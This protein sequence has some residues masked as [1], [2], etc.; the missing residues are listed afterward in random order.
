MN[1]PCLR[2]AWALLAY[3]CLSGSII[4]VVNVFMWASLICML[5]TRAHTNN[6][7]NERYLVMEQDHL[8]NLK[9]VCKHRYVQISTDF[10]MTMV[11]SMVF[12]PPSELPIRR[13]MFVHGIG[14]SALSFAQTAAII[15][16]NG[17]HEVH[18]LDLP[19]FGRLA[20]H[21]R[22]ALEE[23][24]CDDV[25]HFYGQVIKG[26]MRTCG[27]MATEDT[28]VAHSF[29]GFLAARCAIDDPGS[30]GKLVL[31]SPAGLYPTLGCFG[32]HW[33]LL[34]KLGLPQ[35]LLKRL[36]VSPLLRLK[37]WSPAQR[38]HLTL[39]S[40]SRG[41]GDV[42]VAKFVHQTFTTSRWTHPMIEG[43]L[44]SKGVKLAFVHGA[45]DSLTP[46]HQLTSIMSRGDDVGL[47]VKVM[48]DAG[49][50]PYAD[51][52][53]TFANNIIE[54]AEECREPTSRQKTGRLG[55]PSDSSFDV[56]ETRRLVLQGYRDMTWT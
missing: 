41:I 21:Q 45:L 25:V 9:Q 1:V 52:S 39:I 18:C 47:P 3:L 35:S 12:I 11:H 46:L 28:V 49:H 19:G 22:R 20:A 54:S 5:T 17:G 50:C 16:G 14:G 36:P 44:S 13:M 26:Y 33:G 23:A 32:A 56:F 53:A 7:T 40:D 10:G 24:T 29:G 34:F 27:F 51:D 6:S 38:H 2:L 42:L 43:L 30:I 31:V 37:L 48:N 4:V 8:S 55:A 15:A